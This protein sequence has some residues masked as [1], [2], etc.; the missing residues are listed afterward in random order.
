MNLIGDKIYLKENIS[1]ENYPLLLQWFNDLEVV[2]YLYS[3]K[4]ISEFKTVQDAKEFLAEEKD[5]IFWEIY[6]NDGKFIGYASLCD[7]REKERCEFS[8]FILNKKYWGKGLGTE[9]TKIMVKHAF[10]ELGIKTVILETSEFNQGAI[11]VYEKVGFKKIKVVPNDRTVFHNGKWMKSGSVVMEIKNEK[12]NRI[13]KKESISLIK[14]FIES[15]LCNE[16]WYQDVEDHLSAIILYGSTA[17]GAN[18][19]DSDIDILLIL[20]LEIEEKYTAGEY[21]YQFEGREINIVIRSIENLRKIATEGNDEFQKEIFREAEIIWNK[22]GEVEKLL[23]I[24]GL[25]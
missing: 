14:R 22:D 16:K 11:S 20:P 23:K 8:V 6:A 12:Q 2:G 18:R 17:K 9:V 4:R 10:K 7:F 25:K 3:A 13:T 5:E 15:Q 21:F 24:I 19:V 1:E